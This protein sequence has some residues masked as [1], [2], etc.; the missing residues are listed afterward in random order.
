MESYV[1]I[2]R[3]SLWMHALNEIN[4]LLNHFDS[5]LKTYVLRIL[6]GMTQHPGL[7]RNCEL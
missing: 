6:I 2:Q 7:F 1:Q 5:G 3:H 4:P